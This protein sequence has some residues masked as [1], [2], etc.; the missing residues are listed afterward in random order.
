MTDVRA[1]TIGPTPK[2]PIVSPPKT[3]SIRPLGVVARC[4]SSAFS[5]TGS[6]CASFGVLDR[7]RTPSA[8][9]SSSLVSVSPGRDLTAL[10]HEMMSSRLRDELDEATT[11]TMGETG[12]CDFF[13]W[14]YSFDV[15]YDGARREAPALLLNSTGRDGRPERDVRLAA[16]GRAVDVVALSRSL[17]RRPV[18]S[19]SLLSEVEQKTE[20][21]ARGVTAPLDFDNFSVLGICNDDFL[22]APKRG[23]VLAVLGCCCGILAFRVKAGKIM[24]SRRLVGVSSICSAGKENAR[25][26]LGAGSESGA[27]M[28]GGTSGA[29]GGR[30]DGASL[31]FLGEGE[32]VPGNAECE[33]GALV[34]ATICSVVVPT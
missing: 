13:R 22:V 2:R 25:R 1:L 18:P 9:F 27:T 15:R 29:K 8:F 19:L 3:D 32:N 31:A 12:D 6:M 17:L 7:P 16:A 20:S 26:S 33:M 30:A 5:R 34:V 10:A 4:S 21:L 11:P 14:A 24:L 28:T 23:V